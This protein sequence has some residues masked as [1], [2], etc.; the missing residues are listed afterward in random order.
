MRK[1]WPHLGFLLA[2]L[3]SGYGGGVKM[4][5]EV[6]IYETITSTVTQT[7]TTI[8][9]TGS[10][11][12]NYNIVEITNSRGELPAFL[13]TNFAQPE[14]YSET[15]TTPTVTTTLI[16]TISTNSF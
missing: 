9:L 11:V 12:A 13:L 6:L 15:W 16:V 3:A 1:F 10:F 5:P 4:L 2:S 8:I 7:S 14:V